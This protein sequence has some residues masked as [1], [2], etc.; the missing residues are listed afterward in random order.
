MKR[1]LSVVAVAFALVSCGDLDGVLNVVSALNVVNKDGKVV[2][3]PQGSYNSE[4]SFNQEKRELKIKIR[5]AMNGDDLKVT[6]KV[7]AG[8]SIPQNNGSF[9]LQ[10]TQIG[11][12]WNLKGVVRTSITQS[13]EQSLTENCNYR[14]QVVYYAPVYNQYGQIIRYDRYYRYET[15]YGYRQ[16]SYYDRVSTVSSES[17]F[18]DPQTGNRLAEL[19]G[20]DTATERVYSYYG[21]CY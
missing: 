21:Q 13:L 6:L 12:A 9:S 7:P 3:V 1:I 8:S 16:V 18:I 20:N 17:E 19:S 11:Q 4:F 5:D 2:T 15:R 10:S 14:V